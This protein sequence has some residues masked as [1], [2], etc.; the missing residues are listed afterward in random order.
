MW[1]NIAFIPKNPSNFQ[2]LG[3][4]DRNTPYSET[5]FKLHTMITTKKKIRHI[6]F[7]C[8]RRWWKSSGISCASRGLQNFTKPATEKSQ[9]LAI[10]V[11]SCSGIRSI[12]RN[13]IKFNWLFFFSFTRQEHNGTTSGRQAAKTSRLSQASVISYASRTSRRTDRR[14]SD[15]SSVDTKTIKNFFK[16]M[17]RKLC[18]ERPRYVNQPSEGNHG[19]ASE[20]CC[21]T[22]F[23]LFNFMTQ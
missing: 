17:T 6:L 19:D 1:Y 9:S 18:P 5:H 10:F 21:L 13:L 4:F 3:T 11:C 14:G 12:K 8:F 16:E 23:F 15:T 7:W 20:V 2:C 22:R